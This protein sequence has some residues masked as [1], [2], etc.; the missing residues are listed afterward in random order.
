MNTDIRRLYRLDFGSAYWILNRLG[1]EIDNPQLLTVLKQLI[2]TVAF[3]NSAFQ[4]YGS[5]QH[6]ERY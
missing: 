2:M 5:I 6:V 4:Q 3:G 1:L